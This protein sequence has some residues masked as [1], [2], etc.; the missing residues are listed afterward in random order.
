MIGFV[1][2]GG[3]PSLDLCNTRLPTDDLLATPDDV[4]AWLAAAGLATPVAAPCDQDVQ[5]VRALRDDLRVAFV[6]HD[7]RSVADIVGE[8]L[9]GAPGHLAID[10]DSLRASF[11]PDVATCTCLLV[12]ALLD[13]I[14]L[15]R[16][17][18]GR[19]RECAAPDCT[20]IYWDGSRNGSRRWCSM[21]RCGARAKAHTYYARKRGRA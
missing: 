4:T 10:R 5:R 15:A 9:T 14:D 6:A 13:A 17:G 2:V 20:M 12:P 21:E 8:W 1:W 18:I 11:C 19:V 3:R 7:P 16:D